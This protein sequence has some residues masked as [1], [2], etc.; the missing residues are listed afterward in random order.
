MSTFNMQVNI[1]QVSEHASQHSSQQ[2]VK[3]D[4][5]G[6]R[7]SHSAEGMGNGFNLF[8][9]ESEA[10]DVFLERSRQHNIDLR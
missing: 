3:R 10:K 4:G 2:L 8:K 1:Q 7:G 5:L 6:P 9:M